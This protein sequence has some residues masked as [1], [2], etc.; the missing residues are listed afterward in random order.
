[1]HSLKP[2]L[3]RKVHEPLMHPGC[4][5]AMLVE[6]L[7]PQELQSFGSVE[8]STQVPLH[9]VGALAGQLTAHVKVP[10]K[11]VQY[12]VTPVH[13]LVQLPQWEG[14]PTYTQ[15]PLQAIRG[16]TQAASAIPPASAES[17]PSAPFP[18]AMVVGLVS[19][20]ASETSPAAPSGGAPASTPF[21][22][23]NASPPHPSVST[24]RATI[25]KALIDK[26]ICVRTRGDPLTIVR[27]EA[28]TCTLSRR[29]VIGSTLDE[30]HIER[31]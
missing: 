3:Q 20:V 16:L 26:R 18:S 1:L 4:A 12:G 25:E 21:A 7:F 2:L 29:N 23:V 24:A 9:A 19:A 11:G 28:G 17:A 22:T 15:A 30:H 14:L 8:M 31:P 27:F 6:H 10:S 5:L 13:A